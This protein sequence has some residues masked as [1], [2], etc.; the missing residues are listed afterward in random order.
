M[1]FHDE[2]C[3]HVYFFDLELTV[4]KYKAIINNVLNILVYSFRR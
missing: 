2:L 3:I 4:L 1:G